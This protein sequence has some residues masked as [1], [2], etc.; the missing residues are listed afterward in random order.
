MG[1]HSVE[2]GKIRQPL[3][4]QMSALPIEFLALCQLKEILACLSAS[5]HVII[6]YPLISTHGNTEYV[7]LMGP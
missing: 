7:Q 2:E 3:I 1:R 5:N 4:I 6:P